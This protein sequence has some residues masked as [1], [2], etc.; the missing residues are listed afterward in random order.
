MAYKTVWL[1]KHRPQLFQTNDAVNKLLII[2]NVNI[3]NI[4]ISVAVIENCS[5]FSYAKSANIFQQKQ[6]KSL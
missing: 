3:T 2:L 1:V 5:R 6:K 4:E